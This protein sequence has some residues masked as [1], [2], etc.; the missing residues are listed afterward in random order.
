MERLTLISMAAAVSVAA[1][2]A[3]EAARPTE[4]LTRARTL[5]AQADKTQAQR[6][7]PADLQRAH[8][9]LSQADRADRDQKYEDARRDAESAAVD[10]DLAS[11]RASAE[12]AQRAAHEVE[13]SNATL[14]QESLR[15]TGSPD[16]VPTSPDTP[17]MSAY[18][19]APPRATPPPPPPPPPPPVAP[20][21]STPH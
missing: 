12:E 20:D 4:E 17:D 13:R 3:S 7:A 10:A 18:P 15:H 21:D 14:E 2:C 11:A 16:T 19:P 5:V 8:D 1:G 9:E 6:Y